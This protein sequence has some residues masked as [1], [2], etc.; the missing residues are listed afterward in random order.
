[1]NVLFLLRRSYKQARNSTVAAQQQAGSSS[2]SGG[3]GGGGS[4]SGGSDSAGGGGGGL[5]P[6][7]ARGARRARSGIDLDGPIARNWS[8]A[9]VQSMA[10]P[11]AEVHASSVVR[12]GRSSK[13]PDADKTG[14]L[15][16][17]GV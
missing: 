9:S 16:H 8:V 13:F 3:G 5:S 12:R 1:M 14:K 4:G 15:R 11:S 10:F 7:S 6:T 2:S 17:L